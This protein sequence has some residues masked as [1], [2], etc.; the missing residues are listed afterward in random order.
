MG[1]LA[2]LAVAQVSAGALLAIVVLLILTGLLVPR[3]QLK[4]VRADRD[5][6]RAAHD[7]QQE[8]TLKQGMT[9]ERVVDTTEKLLV[10]AEATQHV[11]TEIQR[12]GGEQ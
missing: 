6:W 9:L 7:V 12:A 4:D 2:G 10:Y 3:R 8:I 11:V 5:Y 1:E